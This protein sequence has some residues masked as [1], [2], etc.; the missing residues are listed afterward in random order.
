MHPNTCTFTQMPTVE[1]AQCPASRGFCGDTE[2]R[3]GDGGVFPA[4]R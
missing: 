3:V 2:G 4:L 1:Y